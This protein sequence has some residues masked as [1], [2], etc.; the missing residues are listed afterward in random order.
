MNS[1]VGVTDED[2]LSLSIAPVQNSPHAAKSAAAIAFEELRVIY[3]ARI[4]SEL[5]KIALK[6][7]DL[8]VHEGEVFGFLGPNGAGKTTTMNVLLGF[9]KA[10]GGTAK[11]FGL[12]VTDPRSRQTLG[13]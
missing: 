8:Q 9:V 11:I 3:P 1:P 6:T 7:L 5:P 10:T 13:Y 12:D 4:R 2:K